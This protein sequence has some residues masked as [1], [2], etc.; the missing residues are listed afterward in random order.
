KW[1]TPSRDLI[2]AFETEGD[3]ERFKE[4]IVYYETNWSNYYPS[5]HYPFMYK[6]RSAYSNIIKY[7]YADVL[8]LKAEALIMGSGDLAAAADIIDR[9]RHRAGLNK[10]PANIRGDKEVMLNA[11]LKERR[12]E[13]AFEG[14]RWFDLVRLNKVEEVMNAVFAK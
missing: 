1:V 13:L 9:I 5:D 4:S 14:Q 10:L 12:L 11:L 3:Q 8:L 2:K 7:R 6:C